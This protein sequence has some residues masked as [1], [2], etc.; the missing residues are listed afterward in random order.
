MRP[1]P[2]DRARRD[3]SIGAI[4]FFCHVLTPRT[5]SRYALSTGKIAK[6]RTRWPPLEGLMHLPRAPQARQ[7]LCAPQ[8]RENFERFCSPAERR[9]RCSMSA[10]SAE[11]PTRRSTCQRASSSSSTGGQWAEPPWRAMRPEFCDCCCMLGGGSMP[12]GMGKNT[13]GSAAVLC[14]LD[15]KID[16]AAR[17]SAPTRAE[18]LRATNET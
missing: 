12:L 5:R 3:L 2:L 13:C 16:R 17:A 8:A 11:A 14:L 9:H 7:M 15:A 1:I 10:A 6:M 18:H 4:K